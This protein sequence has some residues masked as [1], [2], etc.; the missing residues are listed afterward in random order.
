MY[1]FFFPWKKS[2]KAD[3]LLLPQFLCGYVK[4]YLKKK[5][6]Y[7][8]RRLSQYGHMLPPPP[9]KIRFTNPDL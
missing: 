6:F 4:A 5:F 8:S 3:L 7:L 9:Q 2:K 1:F